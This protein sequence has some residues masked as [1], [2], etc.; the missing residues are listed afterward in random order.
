MRLEE[1]GKKLLE[2]V[3]PLGEDIIK[4][5]LEIYFKNNPSSV[6]HLFLSKEVSYYTVFKVN[7]SKKTVS[8]FIDFLNSSFVN[9]ENII[10]PMNKIT[11]IEEREDLCLE[12]W[13]DDIYFHLTPFDWGIEEL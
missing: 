11:F 10:I 9:K 13:V 4:E 3:E 8:N 7:Q 2:N 12:V 5:K 1:Y 6:Y